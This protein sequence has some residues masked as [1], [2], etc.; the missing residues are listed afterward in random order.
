MHVSFAKQPWLFEFVIGSEASRIRKYSFRTRK[1]LDI[2]YVPLTN[3]TTR[4]EQRA[5]DK[6]S[7][8]CRRFQGDLCVYCE[9]YAEASEIP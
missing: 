1:L 8:C 5:E 2:C 4:R 9:L 7:S 6:T 3:K